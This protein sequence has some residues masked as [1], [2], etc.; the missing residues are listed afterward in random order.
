MSFIGAVF[1]AVI[2]GISAIASC[3]AGLVKG[4]AVIGMAVE[5]IKAIGGVFIGIGK[6]LGIIE[7]KDMEVDE[8]GDKAIQS[9]L[10]PDDFDSYSAYVDAV[11]HYKTDPEKSAQI[12]E[13]DKVKKG[14]E[15]AAGIS[16]EKFG[17]EFDFNMME[18]L[19]NNKNFMTGKDYGNLVNLIENLQSTPKEA[20]AAA[21]FT[22]DKE[23]SK[24]DALSGVEF[25]VNIE[26][27]NNP[28]I[29]N[30]EA[31]RNVYGM[32]K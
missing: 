10:K 2:G 14:T 7:D 28:G 23:Q 17:K 4:L 18:E 9:G 32:K 24:S 29:S 20:C 5:G 21:K 22:L 27:K 12:S 30:E 31:L 16:I 15:V 1:G 25:L 19:I 11:Q 26:K 6:A 3:A 8:L 13:E